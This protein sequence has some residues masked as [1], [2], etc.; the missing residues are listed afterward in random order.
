MFRPASDRFRR[1]DRFTVLPSR[2]ELRLAF[3]N[4][5][6]PSDRQRAF[7]DWQASINNP[8][9]PPWLP[10]NI[11]PGDYQDYRQLQAR[12]SPPSGR[13]EAMSTAP[14]PGPLASSGISHAGGQDSGDAGPS[15]QV[16]AVFRSV[17]WESVDT[18]VAPVVDHLDV[19]SVGDRPAV[20]ALGREVCDRERERLRAAAECRGRERGP[21]GAVQSPASVR[22]QAVAF[23]KW[24]A[25]ASRPGQVPLVSVL[26]VGGDGIDK[27]G[28]QR[29]RGQ[30]LND[31]RDYC[32]AYRLPYRYWWG[33]EAQKR[34]QPHLN[35]AVSVPRSHVDSMK[36]LVK[37]RWNALIRD[38]GSTSEARWRR[39]C[40]WMIDSRADT[41]PETFERLNTYFAKEVSKRAQKRF[42]D[43]STWGRWWGDSRSSASDLDA[44]GWRSGR[45]RLGDR[46]R[47]QAGRALVDVWRE[48]TDSDSAPVVSLVDEAGQL[49]GERLLLRRW[50]LGRAGSRLIAQGLAA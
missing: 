24:S 30:L 10:D 37:R 35:L 40:V 43:G 38:T 39:S 26:T 28:W 32:R 48:L 9:Y 41:G 5:D 50:V 31:I 49:I 22:A 29:V 46:C 8:A 44:A 19:V 7:F 3:R 17:P 16:R 27:D 2:D 6:T 25:L 42:D 36:R 21:V 20:V 15:G 18:S 34:C 4:A 23:S 1:L 45:L 47:V 33:L 13:G 14:G 12:V 11:R